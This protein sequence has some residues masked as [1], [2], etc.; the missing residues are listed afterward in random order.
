[1]EDAPVRRRSCNPPDS[2]VELI[3]LPRINAQI[4]A[5]CRPRRGP[6]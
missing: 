5:S 6:V 1:M 3:R 2:P 4:N